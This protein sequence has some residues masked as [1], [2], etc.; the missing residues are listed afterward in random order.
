[1][2]V[3]FLGEARLVKSCVCLN[4]EQTRCVNKFAGLRVEKREV[5]LRVTNSLT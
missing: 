4:N 2:H 5:E 3:C 1:M